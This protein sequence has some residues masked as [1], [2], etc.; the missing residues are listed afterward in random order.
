MDL[1]SCFV[2]YR[3]GELLTFEGVTFIPCLFKA[4]TNLYKVSLVSGPT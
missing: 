2:L 3:F 4:A 1:D